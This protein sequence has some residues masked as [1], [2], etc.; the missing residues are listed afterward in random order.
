MTSITLYTHERP[1]AGL[2][3]TDV[4]RVRGAAQLRVVREGQICTYPTKGIGSASVEPAKVSPE[5]GKADL[6]LQVAEE[7]IDLAKCKWAVALLVA[8]W[9]DT[10]IYWLDDGVCS[11]VQRAASGAFARADI[12]ARCC[13]GEYEYE[14]PPQI[15]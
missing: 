6:R 9:N 11:A 13:P 14:L 7:E 8:W 5:A 10:T 2:T 3:S 1:G 4:C 12:E 15:A